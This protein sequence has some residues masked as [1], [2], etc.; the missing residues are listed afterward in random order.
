MNNNLYLE[1]ELIYQI[2]Y[3]FS[4]PD[5]FICK[6]VKINKKTVDCELSK[7]H[8]R[9]I[10]RFDMESGYLANKK[11]ME[12]L[13]FVLKLDTTKNDIDNLNL[14]KEIFIESERLENNLKGLKDIYIN[15]S[16][17]R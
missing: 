6:V 16:W 2:N 4:N 8:N 9:E 15:T 7:E 12:S 13:G 3:R 14:K 11:K 1:K 5:R 10:Y 17:A